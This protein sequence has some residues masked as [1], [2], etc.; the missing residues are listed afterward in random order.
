METEEDEPLTKAFL[1]KE[2]RLALKAT[3][4]PS[5]RASIAMKLSDLAG[6]KGKDSEGKEQEQRRFYLPFISHC[7]SC[8][9]VKLLRD[10]SE[11]KV[12]KQ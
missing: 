12:N 1:V 7:R 8:K 5:D 4:D 10:I 9:L 6:L 11:K 3:T 2:L